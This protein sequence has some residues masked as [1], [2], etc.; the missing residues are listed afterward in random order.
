MYICKLQNIILNL[1]SW[2]ILPELCIFSHTWRFINFHQFITFLTKYEQF[3]SR[4]SPHNSLI[5]KTI[6]PYTFIVRRWTTRK[7]IYIKRRSSGKTL[8]TRK[9]VKTSFYISLLKMDH[10]VGLVI[11]T[12]YFV[13]F[14]LGSS[15]YAL[16]LIAQTTSVLTYFKLPSQVHTNKQILNHPLEKALHIQRAFIS[17]FV[18]M[19]LSLFCC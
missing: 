14:Q 5:R 6:F 11:D 16:N 3:S 13:Y 4:V 10:D 15:H 7:K 17:T 1:E 12:C 8:K 18:F 2:I 19:S 9:A